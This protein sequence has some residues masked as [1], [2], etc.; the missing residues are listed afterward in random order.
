MLRL[1]RFSRAA[2]ELTSRSKMNF[3]LAKSVLSQRVALA[4][5]RKRN[6]ETDPIMRRA[7][8]NAATLYIFVS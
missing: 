8:R 6:A 4:F 5:S 2:I 1:A 7:F 3:P